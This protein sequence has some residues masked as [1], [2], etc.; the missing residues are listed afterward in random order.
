MAHTRRVRLSTSPSDTREEGGRTFARRPSP[1]ER[2]GKEHQ[3]VPVLT[4]QPPLR[5]ER[6]HGQR[7]SVAPPPTCGE[8]LRTHPEAWRASS[9]PR[10]FFHRSLN[11]HAWSNRRGEAWKPLFP[12]RFEAPTTAPR[13][14]VGGTPGPGELSPPPRKSKRQQHHSAQPRVVPGATA[15]HRRAR[16][17]NEAEPQRSATT[18]APPTCRASSTMSGVREWSFFHSTSQRRT[19]AQTAASTS[20]LSRDVQRSAVD[21]PA[22]SNFFDRA[23]SVD[24]Q[25]FPGPSVA[26][27]PSLSLRRRARIPPLCFNFFLTT[28]SSRRPCRERVRKGSNPLNPHRSGARADGASYRDAAAAAS[29]ARQRSEGARGEPR[30]PRAKPARTAPAR[31]N[32]RGRGSSIV[33]ILTPN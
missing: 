6:Q 24:A 13:A 27:D 16:R 18:P 25:V 11:R 9:P 26:L 4:S 12:P 28:V 7:P 14:A 30:T 15:A 23:G 8:Y 5:G 32:G 1:G 2:G 3:G 29:A 10:S 33:R 31:T 17:S 20:L 21:S 22:R 19:H